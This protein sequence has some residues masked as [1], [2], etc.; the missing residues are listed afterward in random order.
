MLYW[1]RDLH[2]KGRKH[3]DFF[4]LE[5]KTATQPLT[6]PLASDST[7]K[8]KRV[9]MQAAVI[10]PDYQEETGLLLHNGGKEYRRFL[11]V[12]LVSRAL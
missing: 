3:I 9:S 11:R 12:F 6:A 1:F 8:R 10:D 5:I 2:S 7:G 4:G